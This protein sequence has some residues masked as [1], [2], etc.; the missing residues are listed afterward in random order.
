MPPLRGPTDAAGRAGW[1]ALALV[2][3]LALAMR[4]LPWQ[5]VFANDRIYY[6]D[7]DCY[8]R[9]RK[10]WVYLAG[11]PKT[12]IHDY[13]QGYPHGTGVIAAP[14]MEYLLAAV[15]SPFRAAPWLV[16]FVER[17]IALIPPLVGALTAALLCRFTA[18]IAGVSAGLAAGLLLAVAPTHV[19]ASVLGRFDNEMAEPLLLLLAFAGYA[20][21]LDDADRTRSWIA[22]GCLACLY[23]SVWRGGIALLSLVGIDVLVRLWGARR[24]PQALR[25]IGRGAALMYA[26]AA[27]AL[28][29]ACLSDLWG[30]RA[31]FGFNVLSWFHVV[32]FAGAAALVWAVSRGLVR[33]PKVG[34]ACGLAVG[35]PLA[36]AL[37]GE[38]A[39]GFS[40]LR[41]GNP[42]VD[43]IIQYQP[44]TD[45]SVY[46]RN[47]G[48][49]LLLLPC[50]L[51]LLTR[52][53]HRALRVRRFLILWSLAALAATIARQ[54]YA[55][56]LALN[57]AIAAGLCVAWALPRIPLPR[58]ISS[59]ALVVA[60]LLLQLPTL[61]ALRAIQE[62]RTA[63]V[64]RGDVEETMLWLRAH[65]PPPGDP[66]RP[67][68]KPAYGVLARW[69]YGGWI[70]A[71]AQRPAVATNYGTETHGMQEAARF[72][73]ATDE[74]E[75]MAVLR[76]NGVRYLVVD[77]VVTDL[78]M[79]AALIGDPTR[80]LHEYRDPQS[81]AVTYLPT[82]ALQRLVVARLFYADGSAARAGVFRFAPVEGVRLLFESSS[83]ARVSG[84]PWHVA[85]LKVFEVVPGARLLVE[86]SPGSDV[87]LTQRLE[88]NRGR[89]VDFRIEKIAD[90][91]GRAR[92]AAV[93][94]PKAGQ[95]TGA[96]G[97][98]ML[99]FDGRQSAV[100]VTAADIDAQRQIRVAH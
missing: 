91:D 62:Q 76:R 89:R 68:R 13:Y 10:L 65:T 64:F 58:A 48:L 98:L 6:F 95:A 45:P 63:D 30:S 35:L 8:M 88:T 67:D 44:Q 72:F 93:Y 28:A 18:A 82:P 55:E 11:F 41:G 71:V 57:S 37:G 23:L 40:L 66:F 5:Q 51:L 77:N 92:F 22:A 59:A 12:A 33:S 4:L 26:V 94:A 56:Y 32:L 7:P 84:L 60:V 25:S 1:I 42:W 24:S 69:D 78:P 38:L 15:L 16:P 74:A 81:G 19:E 2:F 49:A 46:A 83:H 39:S 53:S 90:A 50:G 52:E 29:L 75:M 47:F 100:E 96:V 87:V 79:Y 20:R 85:K 3:A 36:V 14:T 73:L 43:S 99:E 34:V 80:V 54:R 21:T 27:V 61:A 17:A 31:L 86:A 97:P 70:E 9:L